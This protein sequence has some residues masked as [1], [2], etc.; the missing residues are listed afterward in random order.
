MLGA[1]NPRRLHAPLAL[2]LKI[3]DLRAQVAPLDRYGLTG[4]SAAMTEGARGLAGGA[5]AA[6]C[7]F[8]CRSRRDGCDC[9]TA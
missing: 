7:R 4:L 9:Q 6:F 3:D 5:W 8:A 2:R 1:Q